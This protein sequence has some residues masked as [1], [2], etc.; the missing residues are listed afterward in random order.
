MAPMPNVRAAPVEAAAPSA[1]AAD[2]ARAAAADA[3]AAALSAAVDV[4][5]AGEP[6]E[7]QQ[8]RDLFV[9]VWHEDPDDPA[10]SSAVL[11]ALAV[12]GSY[13]AG[14][15]RGRELAGACVGFFGRSDGAW[16]L[17]SHIAGVIPRARGS[18]V[19]FALKTHQRA[20]ALSRGVQRVSWTFDPLVARNVY[21]NATKLGA[22]VGAYLPEFYGPMNDAINGGDL[23][24]RVMAEWSLADETVAAACS[25]HP[26]EPDLTAWRNAGAA[27]ALYPDE[28]DRPVTADVDAETVLI[29][30]PHDIEEMRRTDPR[31]ALAWRL[32]LRDVLGGVLADGGRIAGF[33]KRGTYV[34]QRGAA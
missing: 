23:T 9:A 1:T 19:G 3:G 16:E 4:R 18:N 5:E 13:V 14:A 24:D 8:V 12:C 25:G 27:A 26:D 33:A 29:T 20:W 31:S 17:H 10:M 34:V 32:A 15:W 2:V 30:I 21:F 7:L 22:A 28:H 6:D 11:R